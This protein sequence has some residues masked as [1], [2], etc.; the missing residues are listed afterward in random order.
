MIIKAS[1]RSG[2][3]NLANHLASTKDN[4][5]VSLHEV[6]GLIGQSLHAAFLEIDAS[7]HATRCEKPLFSVSFNPPMGADVTHDQFEKAFDQLEN[8]LGLDNQPRVVVLHEKE[9]RRHAHVVWSRI[10]VDR[11]KAIH[12]AHFKQKCTDISRQLYLEHGWELPKGLENR[13]ERDPFNVSISEWQSL[14]RK[15]ID[16]RDI[17]ALCQDA[18]AHSDGASGFKHALE[19]KGLF[20]ARGDKRGFVVVDHSETIY[21]LSRVGGLKTKELKRRLG[22]PDALP[23][24]SDTSTRIRTIYNRQA[25]EQIK[26]LKAKQAGEMARLNEQK[27]HLVEIQKAERRELQDQQRIKRH[28]TEKSAKERYRRGL[29]GLFDKVSGRNRRIRLI[30]EKEGWLL[31][32]RQTESREKM[33]FRH[34]LERAKLQKPIVELRDQH[35]LE[36][37][38]LARAIHL[39]RM[40]DEARS[41]LIENSKTDRKASKMSRDFDRASTDKVVSRVERGQ[42]GVPKYDRQN[43][44]SNAHRS[45]KL[46]R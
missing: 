15:S 24:V 26:A 3:R 40:R 32:K 11:S 21:S 44:N 14:K 43:V 25:F 34:N 22:S 31:Q 33:I 27:A 17:K 7:S 1:Q 37:V 38:Q 16:A 42:G 28:I 19:E 13:K 20:L 30:N 45:R 46:E 35:R 12:M 5:H 41:K 23:S 18:W 4:D 36:R 39:A 9:G 6:R 8:K 2:A 10:D 29:R